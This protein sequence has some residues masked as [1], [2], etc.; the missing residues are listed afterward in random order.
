MREHAH[1][2]Y[3]AALWLRPERRRATYALYAL[4]RTLDDLVDDAAAGTRDRE[5][6]RAELNCWRAWLHDPEGHPRGEAIL[7]AVRATM[8]RYGIPSHHFLDLIDGLEMDLD[9]RRY[10]TV[11]DL[12]LYC[13]RVASTVGLAMCHVL[14]VRDPAAYSHAAE[15]GVAMQLT[16]ILRDV[17]EDR[18]NGRVYL[19]RTLLAA[20]AW[21]EERLAEGR[22][23][24]PFRLMLR[25]LIDVARRYYARGIRG[26]PYLSRDA[27]FAILIAARC[28]AAIL[29][30]IEAHDHDVFATRAHVSGAGKLRIALRAAVSP[31]P[32]RAAVPDLPPGA[33][34]GASLLHVMAHATEARP[35]VS[36]A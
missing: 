29:D 30:E 19:P 22:V 13:F 20:A 3:F 27:R 10:E 11:A 34:D 24:E 35:L 36:P 12:A 1:T 16:N 28:Y 2:F 31:R 14:D 26:I 15:L 33:P 7:P 9:N 6:V 32:R 8:S 18:D 4:F 25:S 5:S 23:D 21:D 17:K